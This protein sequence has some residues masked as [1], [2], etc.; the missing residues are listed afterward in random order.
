MMH[1][2]GMWGFGIFIWLINLLAIGLV[3]YFAVRMA[4]KEKK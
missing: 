2:W 3:V 4:L 1:G